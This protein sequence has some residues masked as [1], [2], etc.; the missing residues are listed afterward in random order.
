MAHASGF[1]RRMLLQ[2]IALG[3]LA[4]CVSGAGGGGASL[5][6]GAIA[7][8][9]APRI[10]FRIEQLGRV[11]DDP[12]RWMKFIPETGTR[13]MG[14]LPD[15][16]RAHLEAEAAYAG[17]ALAP[18]RALA[19]EIAAQMAAHLPGDEAPPP[20]WSGDWAYASHYPE[21][22]GHA[23]YTRISVDAG[24]GP[25]IVLDEA[26]RAEGA[27]YY[28]TTGHQPSP[29]HRYYAWA[30]D[31]IGNDRHRICVKDMQTGAV[32][33]LVPEDAYG[34]G[35][36]VFSPSSRFLF[37]IWRDARNRPTRVYRT[38]VDG[39][40]SVLVYE[41]TN[42]ALFMQIKRTAAA[43]YIAITVSGP[44]T[45]EVWLI[46]G[47][48]E[49]A[50]PQVVFPRRDKVRY[51]VDEWAGALLVL[52]DEG[53]AI[54]NALLAMPAEAPQTTLVAHRPGSQILEVF[55]FEKALVR[56]ERQ[57]GLHQ[58]ILLF[59]DGSEKAIGFD[60]A[61]Y[62]LS[63]PAGQDYSADQCRILFQSPRLP[64]QWMDVDLKTGALSLVQASGRAGYDPDAYVVERM[65]AP[66]AD[67]AL[68]PVTLLSRRGV[69][70][71]GS[72][73][74]VLYGYGAYGVSSEPEFSVPALALVDRG[75]TYAIAHV[76]GGSE[77]GRQWFLDGRRFS[78]RNSF[79]DFVACAEHLCD[80]GVTRKGA[81]VAYGL[82]AGGLLVAGAMNEA[83][84]MWAGV[85]AQV[86]FVDMLNTMSD[87]DHP[88]VPLFRPD[89]GDPL[90]DPV[91]YDYMF[92]I[93]PY[94]NVQ[95]TAY[96]P[97]L[98]TSGLKDDRVG[99]WEAAKLVAEVRH[100]STGAAPAI[101]LL[102]ADAGHQ[103]SGSRSAQ[104]QEM[105]LCWAFAEAAVSGAL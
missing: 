88:L 94:E 37:W 55:P 36:L 14:T 8:P 2:T 90:A 50:T 10:T 20:V 35:G 5:A 69:P 79:T 43:G 26:A 70:R 75:W 19:P 101:L 32:S 68:V 84:D 24:A 4:G 87:A 76:R 18:A 53:G 63:V 49:I 52:T 3:A 12:Y 38:P 25:E 99:Y 30:E 92:S 96:P 45:S 78:K 83:P 93:S 13:E 1:S 40:E 72:M 7:P 105:S 89:W 64:V 31:V 58:L 33:V 59:A 39:G 62:T 22:S 85:I 56:L 77:R 54:D 41:E 60:E 21:G 81:I 16:I 34:Y 80:L 91:A 65:F 97:L 86:P 17:A 6:A 11:R 28:R 66:A 95:A 74:C 102:D 47:A 103:S 104:F 44:D 51:E 27:A 67:G 73:P 71:D 61:A 57:E 48:D 9:V 100:T 29:D 23:V 82:S 46:S 98:C 42:P 15:M